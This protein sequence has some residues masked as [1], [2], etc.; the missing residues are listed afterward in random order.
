[1]YII[2]GFI[3]YNF[4]E[5]VETQHTTVMFYGRELGQKGE[6]NAIFHEFNIISEIESFVLI[7]IY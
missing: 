2:S 7:E 4:L 3:I 6:E 5:Y 1:M